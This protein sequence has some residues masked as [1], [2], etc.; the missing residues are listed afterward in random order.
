L[1]DG[2]EIYEDASAAKLAHTALEVTETAEIE[3]PHEPAQAKRPTRTASQACWTKPATP[4]RTYLREMGVVP[5]LTRRTRS[6]HR[7]RMERGQLL[8]LKTISRSPIVLKALI[9]VAEELR[10]GSVPLKRSFTST[11]KI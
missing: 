11:M 1:N 3:L 10:N 6:V 2:I 8:V 4:V 5:L 7:E 9:A